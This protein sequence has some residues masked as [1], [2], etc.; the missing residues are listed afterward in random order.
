M[1]P[2]ETAWPE[3]GDLVIATIARIT[4]Y[5]AYVLLD[6]YGKEGLLHISEVSSGWIRN[7]RHFVR[8]G[9]K[10]VLKVLRVDVEKGHVDLS[11]RRV[12]KREKREKILSWKK[13]RKSD[14]LLRSVSEKLK[15]PFEEVYE[16]AGALIEHEFGG[17]YEGL[18]KAAK[19][20]AA[21]LIGIGVPKEMAEAIA[22]IAKEKIRIPMVK[23]KGTL[24]LQCTKPKGV[25]LIQEALLSAQEIGKPLGARVRVYVV[26][27]PR[28]RIEVSAED[29]KEAERILQR[30]AETA[31]KTITEAG[32]EGAFEREK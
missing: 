11:L 13:D 23:V 26:A 4:D 9:Q 27:P 2:K 8:E 32:G 5:G 21:V 12:T 29:Y 16:K 1:T 31:L 24:K 15:I 28:Y 30:A 17:V 19:E 25:A 10:V 6:E 14:S 18:E 20:G 7:I 22:D 3:V